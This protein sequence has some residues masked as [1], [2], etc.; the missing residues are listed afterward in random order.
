MRWVVAILIV[1]MAAPAAAQNWVRILKN[2]PAERFDEEDL[3][4]FLDN[5]RKALKEGKVNETF[6]WE[7]PNTK[8]RGEITVLRQYESKGRPCRRRRRE[9]RIGAKRAQ[10][11]WLHPSMGRVETRGVT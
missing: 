8:A 3:S 1:A 11:S 4:L 6:K 7:N 9:K 5:G 10:I 2:T